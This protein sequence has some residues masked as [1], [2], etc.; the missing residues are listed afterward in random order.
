LVFWYLRLLVM[1]QVWCGHLRVRLRHRSMGSA[2]LRRM[3][4]VIG[5]VQRLGIAT[6][7]CLLLFGVGLQVLRFGL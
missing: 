4:F 6:V 2:S 5:P 3:R 1:R 7:V